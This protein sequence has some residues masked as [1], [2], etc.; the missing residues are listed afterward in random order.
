MV[1]T[2]NILVK[3][4]QF[5]GMLHKVKRQVSL[6]RGE[7]VCSVVLRRR[8]TKAATNG[9]EVVDVDFKAETFQCILKAFYAL[10]LRETKQSFYSPQPS[11]KQN[12]ISLTLPL[13]LDS[14]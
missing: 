11:V 3:P 12:R 2:T 4:Q 7:Q 14:A 1:V 8:R 5:L 10:P 13:N 6:L 9:D